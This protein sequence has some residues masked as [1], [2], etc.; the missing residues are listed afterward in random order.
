MIDWME[1]INIIILVLRL[2]I[3]IKL[4]IVWVNPWRGRQLFQGFKGILGYVV[5]L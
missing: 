4:Y 3:F 5:F 2:Y 1:V